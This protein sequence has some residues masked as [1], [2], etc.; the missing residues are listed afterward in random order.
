MSAP[1]HPP[2]VARKPSRKPVQ[3]RRVQLCDPHS[4]SRPLSLGTALSPCPLLSGVSLRGISYGRLSVSSDSA[5]CV[6]APL[7]IVPWWG[8]WL[9]LNSSATYWPPAPGRC[10]QMISHVRWC[11]FHVLAPES[12]TLRRDG[13]WVPILG[14]NAPCVT[15]AA[16]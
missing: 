1:A 7:D 5:A 15:C 16:G 2:C 10:A 4:G 12:S 11:G 9:F 3:S 8:V 6:T 14:P 13:R